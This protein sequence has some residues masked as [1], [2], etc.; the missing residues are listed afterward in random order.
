MMLVV[1]VPNQGTATRV[2]RT[3][4][5]L[6]PVDLAFEVGLPGEH[7]TSTSSGVLKRMKPMPTCKERMIN[8]R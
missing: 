3:A 6:S 8:A 5:G 7:G 2:M 4:R 1:E